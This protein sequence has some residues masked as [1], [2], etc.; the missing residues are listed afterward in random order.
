M[1]FVFT[2]IGERTDVFLNLTQN[3]VDAGYICVYG[4]QGYGGTGDTKHYSGGV[5]DVT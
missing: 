4:A 5:R 2:E 3:F 1:V